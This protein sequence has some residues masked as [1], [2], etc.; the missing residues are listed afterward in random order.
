M[1]VILITIILVG[2]ILYLVEQFVPMAP[3]IQTV[4]RVVVVLF[5]L[6]WLLRIFGVA[7]FPVPRMR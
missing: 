2:L 3:P 1:L 6:I 7:D 4:F 5:L